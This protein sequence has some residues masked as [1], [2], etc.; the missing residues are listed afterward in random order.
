MTDLVQP[1]EISIMGWNGEEW[2]FILSKIPAWY[3]REICPQYYPTMVTASLP[4]IGDYPRNA[5][6]ALKMMNFVGIY[7]GDKIIRLSTVALINNHVEDWEMQLMLENEMMGYNNR[8]FQSG[9]ASNFFQGLFLTM[10]KKIFQMLTTF[11][12]PSS[13]TE[14][15]PSTN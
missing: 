14:K 8:F 3:G 4:K 7:A 9:K 10:L 2:K 12:E 11:S 15:Q 13:Q 1:K 5:D 6:I